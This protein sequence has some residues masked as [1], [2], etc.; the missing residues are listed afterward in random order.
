MRINDPFEFPWSAEV[1]AMQFDM[2]LRHNTREIDARLFK[3]TW[4]QPD[5]VGTVI[6]D[7]SELACILK[8]KAVNG[9]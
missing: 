7:Q 6:T 2:A 5:F 1:L 4:D 3:V 8:W 9:D